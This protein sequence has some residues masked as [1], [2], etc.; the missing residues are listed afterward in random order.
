V[1]HAATT[2]VPQIEFAAS[3]N[4]QE[5]TKLDENEADAATEIRFCPALDEKLLM[6]CLT[7]VVT[8]IV[9]FMQLNES[10]FSLQS[11]TK[12]SAE[13]RDIGT[14]FWSGFSVTMAILQVSNLFSAIGPRT[15]TALVGFRLRSLCLH[16]CLRAQPRVSALIFVHIPEEPGK[17]GKR[18][19][20]GRKNTGWKPML[21]CSP[22]RRAISQ[23]GVKHMLS[24]GFCLDECA[25]PAPDF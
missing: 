2:S 7:L 25:L 10:G 23:S 20:I 1:I 19:L 15:T 5:V 16:F 14:A 13:R 22:D 9:V 18:R 12:S 24:W 4:R 11:M 3:Q 17:L 8:L 21:H 6:Y